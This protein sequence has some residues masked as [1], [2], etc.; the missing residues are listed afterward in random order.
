MCPT[1]NDWLSVL[2]P[3]LSEPLF[4]SAAVRRLR[5][6]ARRLSGRGRGV[7]EARLGPGPG[8]VDLSLQILEPDLARLLAERLPE[9]YLASFLRRWSEPGGPFSRVPAVWL[10]YDM[11]REPEEIPPAV[12]CAKLPPDAEPGWLVDSLLPALHGK[13]L[14]GIQRR[15]VSLCREAIPPPARLLYAFSLRSRGRDAVRLEIFGLEPHAILDYLRAVAPH[16]DPR[17]EDVAPLFAGVERIH[18]SF[19]LAPSGILP[20][21]GIEGS[22]SRLP[23]REP[24]WKELLDGVVD[25]GLCTPGKRTAAL[26]WT[27]FDTF[28]TAPEAWP[29]D[30]AGLA[31]SCV[32]SLSHLKV[33]CDPGRDLEAKVYLM[34]GP[35]RSGERRLERQRQLGG[36]PL[37]T[38]HIMGNPQLPEPA[39]GLS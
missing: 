7:L 33:V 23:W 2:Q 28:W 16:A 19:D 21:I 39:V 3:H 9:P 36:E 14:T 8:A 24:R 4:D 15:L 31:V 10:E 35:W 37:A 13:P 18:L 27:G 1:C 5:T 20:R 25:K 26:S 12:A 17:V 30:T 6:L 11:D 38:G 34:F 29:V 22:F 32:R